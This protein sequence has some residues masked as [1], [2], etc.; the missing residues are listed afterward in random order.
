MLQK[1]A[2]QELHARMSPSFTR[3][4]VVLAS[5][6]FILGCNRSYAAHEGLTTG[7]AGKVVDVR[8]GD[9]L[10]LDSGLNVRL[11]EIEA[12]RDAWRDRPADPFGKEATRIL[13]F[14]ALGRSAQLYY[15]GLL[16]D[17]YER[18]LAHAVVT[19]EA[20]R[21]VWLN[22]YQVRQGA[23]RVRSYADNSARA[24]MLYPLEV[25]AR[26][27]G[28]GLWALNAYQLRDASTLKD[29]PRGLVLLEDEV[30]ILSE[31][32][33]GSSTVEVAEDGG[34]K[35]SLGYLLARSDSRIKLEPGDRIRVRGSVRR[36]GATVYIVLDHWAQI[37]GPL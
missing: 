18:A 35:L 30:S 24:T 15:G 27:Q 25:E 26:D 8:D 1:G 13:E 17:R 32:S 37:E 21:Q 29:V 20:G 9:L 31:V 5:S 4:S 16:R 23:A 3:R 6:A 34:L 28:R 14:A 2:N 11:A 22:G 33:A 10:I 36:D 12:P 7:E 19:D